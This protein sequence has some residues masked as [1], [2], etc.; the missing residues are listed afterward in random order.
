MPGGASLHV[1]THVVLKKYRGYDYQRRM[2]NELNL[3]FL[4]NS[5]LSFNTSLS[6]NL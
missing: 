6:V 3:N 4:Q 2:N 1:R 5:L